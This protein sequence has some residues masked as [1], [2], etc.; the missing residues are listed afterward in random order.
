MNKSIAK[1][2]FIDSYRPFVLCFRGHIRGLAAT[3]LLHRS[4]RMAALHFR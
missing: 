2:F 3:I 4:E 1:T